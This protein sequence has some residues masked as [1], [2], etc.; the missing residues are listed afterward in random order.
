MRRR[1]LEK[2]QVA[3]Q[4]S[5]LPF[6]TTE[7]GDIEEENFEEPKDWSI[8]EQGLPIFGSDFDANLSQAD[9]DGWSA[10]GDSVAGEAA[11]SSNK[12]P[13][14][15]IVDVEGATTDGLVLGARKSATAQGVEHL[16]IRTSNLGQFKFP[17]EKKRLSGIFGDG[18]PMKL[19][20]PSLQPGP[21][22]LLSLSIHVRAKADF[23]PVVKTGEPPITV[24]LFCKV[25]RN[26]D[27]LN[28]VD[29]RAKRRSLLGGTCLSPVFRT[30]Q[31]ADSQQ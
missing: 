28:Y 15:D 16:A 2:L 21:N 26:V 8:D 4:S 7:L 20:P 14:I 13:K 25:V 24:P 18:I 6:E 17:W 9:F 11:L 30:A 10:V 1:W 5:P 12:K 19:E 23:Q 27:D 22:S 3:N 29:E 31:W